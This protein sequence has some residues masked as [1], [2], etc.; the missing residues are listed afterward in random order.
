MIEKQY[1]IANYSH[2]RCNNREAIENITYS[3]SVDHPYLTPQ[4][5]VLRLELTMIELP[6]NGRLIS[7]TQQKLNLYTDI[8]Q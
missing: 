5:L 8:S 3:P 7:N 2:L 4:P 6:S 1:I